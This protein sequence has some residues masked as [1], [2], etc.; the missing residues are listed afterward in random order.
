MQFYSLNAVENL[1]A[2]YRD[3]GGKAV[4]V[5]EGALLDDMV[6]YGDGLKTC[7]AMVQYLNDSSS[8]YTVRF[9]NKMPRKYAQMI[10]EKCDGV[11]DS[12]SE[13]A[14]CASCSVML[15]N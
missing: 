7:V 5:R 6:M 3:K 9:Y 8:A 13:I 4:L 15:V 1:A 14:E 2:R 11:H 12:V 10:L